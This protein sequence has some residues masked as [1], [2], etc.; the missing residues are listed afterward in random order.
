MKFLRLASWAAID[1][2]DFIGSSS[3]FLS[4]SVLPPRRLAFLNNDAW[5]YLWGS[6]LGRFEV[7]TFGGILL[8]DGWK[9]LVV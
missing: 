5:A 6:P 8:D 1:F 7:S 9:L 3:E 2:P 4:A